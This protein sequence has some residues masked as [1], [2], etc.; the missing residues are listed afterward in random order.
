MI[1]AKPAAYWQENMPNEPKGP[2]KGRDVKHFIA[3][4]RI[5][6]DILPGSRGNQW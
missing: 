3:M 2:I 1:Y 5:L 4:H 6:P